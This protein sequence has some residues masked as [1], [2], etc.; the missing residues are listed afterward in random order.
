LF[1]S[2]DSIRAVR[3]VQL[4]EFSKGKQLAEEFEDYQALIEI[5]D[6]QKD[7]E[8]LRTYIEQYTDKVRRNVRAIG[9]FV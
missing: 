4:K 6:E 1:V 3:L 9:L 5:C 7:V 2:T 8:Q